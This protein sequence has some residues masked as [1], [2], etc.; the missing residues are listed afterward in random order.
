MARRTAQTTETTPC[1]RC[2]AQLPVRGAKGTCPACGLA[3]RFVDA[4]ERPCVECGTAVVLLPGKEA[5]RCT[6]CGAWQAADEGRAVQAEATCPRCG[7]DIPVPL[8][9]NVAVCPHCKSRLELAPA[10]P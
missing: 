5:V 1:P 7:R 4:P 10:R 2:G 6:A 3:V 8:E 9:A